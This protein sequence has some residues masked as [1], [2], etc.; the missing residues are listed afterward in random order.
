MKARQ[1]TTTRIT[2]KTVAL[3]SGF[4]GRGHKLADPR[5]HCTDACN[6]AAYS[7]AYHR[8]RSIEDDEEVGQ[9]TLTDDHLCAVSNVLEREEVC[10]LSRCVVTLPPVIG[11]CDRVAGIVSCC[12]CHCNCEIERKPGAVPASRKKLIYV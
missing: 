7:K 12:V 1:P 10:R 8:V 4:G 2:M 5:T 3:P 11:K 9:E 6:C